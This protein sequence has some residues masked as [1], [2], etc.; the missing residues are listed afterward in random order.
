MYSNALTGGAQCLAI[1]FA[2]FN[3]DVELCLHKQ[4]V[5]EKAWY[6]IL[7][8]IIALRHKCKYTCTCI[9]SMGYIMIQ[10]LKTCVNKLFKR[11][12]PVGLLLGCTIIKEI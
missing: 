2:S 1:N 12:G 3:V 10:K 6:H 9:L 4:N 11:Y 8:Y 5:L 7:L